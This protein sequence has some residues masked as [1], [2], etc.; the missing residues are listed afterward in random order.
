MQ[1]EAPSYE[2]LLEATLPKGVAGILVMSGDT[3]KGLLTLDLG[4]K[5]AY[6]SI[7]IDTAFDATIVNNGNVVILTA[8]DEKDEIHRRIEKLD[9]EG[10]RFRETGCELYTVPFPDH[11][12]VTPIVA[13]E[14]GRPVITDEW[15]QIERQLLQMDNLALVVVDPLASFVLAD[16]N[17]DPSHGAFVTGYFASLATKTKAT[18]LMVHH[19][20]KIDMKYPVRTPEHARN[21]IRGTSA[22]V[23]GVRFAIG[24][25]PLQKV[26]LKQSVIKWRFHLKEIKL[27]MVPLL[28]LTVLLIGRFVYL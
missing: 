7:G 28:N 22:L 20:T 1:G 12:G 19:M 23:D 10:R 26:R 27:F 9:T 8:E 18:F 24:L 14:N 21:L 11:G 3:G 4:M 6:G 13:I 2:Y 17:A 16:I 15:R 25:W 5:I